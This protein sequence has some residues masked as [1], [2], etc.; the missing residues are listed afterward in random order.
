MS[1]LSLSVVLKGTVP[2]SCWV[3]LSPGVRGYRGVVLGLQTSPLLP[4]D[5]TSC[6]FLQVA[7]RTPRREWP[8][9]W[10]SEAYRG[11]W[12]WGEGSEEETSVE[13]APQGPGGRDLSVLEFE[14]QVWRH[15]VPA[16][17]LTQR[18]ASLLIYPAIYLKMGC[19]GVP[20]LDSGVHPWEPS[21]DQG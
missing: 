21:D 10:D 20:K 11:S 9:S 3:C 17:A 5:C 14:V 8:R 2:P 18:P 19:L 4:W 13:A 7:C 12:S 16:F 6:C 1:H 15:G